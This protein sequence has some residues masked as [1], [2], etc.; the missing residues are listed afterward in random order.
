MHRSLSAGVLSL[1]GLLGS[2]TALL[3]KGHSVSCPAGYFLVLQ[4]L[5]DS[6]QADDFFVQAYPANI[7]LQ[8]ILLHGYAI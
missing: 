5:A 3:H 1:H 2:G 7:V 8:M 4:H 6:F